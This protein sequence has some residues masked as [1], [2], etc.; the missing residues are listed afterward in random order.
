MMIP[1]WVRGKTTPVESGLKLEVIVDHIDH[2]CQLAGNAL[3]AGIGT[4]LDGGYG[5]EQTP[6][7]LDTIA[8]LSRVPDMLAIRG[9][10]PVDINNVMHGNYIRFLRHAWSSLRE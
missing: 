3:H 4:D 6:A 7:D 2:V 9:F 5:T 8:D 1:G 10:S